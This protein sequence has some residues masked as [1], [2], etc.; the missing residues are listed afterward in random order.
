[1]N[2]EVLVI[3][4]RMINKILWFA[5]TLVSCSSGEFIHIGGYIQ[6]HNE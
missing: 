3:Y 2:L 4:L 1:M 5:T 6:F